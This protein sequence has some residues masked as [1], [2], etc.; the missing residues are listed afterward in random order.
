MFYSIK[1]TGGS[2]TIHLKLEENVKQR[3][4]RDI[5]DN[6]EGNKGAGNKYKEIRKENNL[7]LSSSKEKMYR[8]TLNSS[9]CKKMTE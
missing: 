4:K 8:P 1:D 9:D 2:K 7:E 5:K 3:H 6:R